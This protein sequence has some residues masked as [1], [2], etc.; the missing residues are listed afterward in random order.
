VHYTDVIPVSF[1]K[2]GANLLASLYTFMQRGDIVLPS[3][4]TALIA[5]CQSARSVPNRNTPF[6]L[7]KTAQNSMDSLDSLR[8]AIANLDAGIPEME[9][10]E[11]QE[12]EEEITV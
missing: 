5:D 10:E 8:L 12:G 3:K 7:E 6:I 4:F 2:K 9:P 11:E 1:A